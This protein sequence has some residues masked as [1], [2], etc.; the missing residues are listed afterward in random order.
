MDNDVV[1]SFLGH[2]VDCNLIIYTPHSLETIHYLPEMRLKTAVKL[3]RL[4]AKRTFDARAL[5][6]I[7][8]WLVSF[9]VFRNWQ[10]N[11]NMLAV[12]SQSAISSTVAWQAMFLTLQLF[13]L[14]F[15]VH[16]LSAFNYH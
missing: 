9:D 12:Q 4:S 1:G 15:Q 3:L 11:R 8:R 2:G 10:S 13:S 5:S 6:C 7:T 16:C 14:T